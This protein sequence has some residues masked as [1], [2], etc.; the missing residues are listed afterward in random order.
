M[1]EKTAEKDERPFN[2]AAPMEMPKLGFDAIAAVQAQASG[3]PSGPAASMCPA[4]TAL[5]MLHAAAAAICAAEVSEEERISRDEFVRL[6]AK[7]Y[8]AH[9]SLEPDRLDRLRTIYAGAVM[10]GLF[11]R[12]VRA[13]VKQAVAESVTPPTTK[14][15][16]H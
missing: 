12:S 9:R 8:D 16:M 2:C 3:G 15:K 11:E 6:A 4:C 10:R 14:E 13:S 5:V 1:A 7:V